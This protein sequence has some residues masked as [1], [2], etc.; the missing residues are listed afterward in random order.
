MGALAYE[1]GADTP[2]KSDEQII[3]AEDAY[4]GR[5]IKGLEFY[6][7]ALKNHLLADHVRFWW[8]HANLKST[9]AADVKDFLKR[10]PDSHLGNRLRDDWLKQAAANRAWDDFAQFPRDKTEDTELLCYQLQY[11][12]RGQDKA[13]LATAKPL[14]F[15]GRSQPESCDPVL[16]RLV[17]DG[18]VS[19]DEI[20]ERVRLAL[21]AGQVGVAKKVND[22]LPN[23]QAMEE[24]LLDEARRNPQR[25]LDKKKLALRTRGAKEIVIYAVSQVAR[26]DAQEAAELWRNLGTHFSA[27]DQGYV[28]GQI[29]HRGAMDHDTEALAWYKKA[30]LASLNDTQLAWKARAALRV[31]AWPEVVAAIDAMTPQERD[32]TA[33]RYWKARALKAI[34]KD[35]ESKELLGTLVGDP[36]YYGQLARE[37]LGAELVV[38]DAVANLPPAEITDMEGQASIKRALLL[39]RIG[40]PQDATREW[41]WAIRNF[42]D[43][44]LVAASQVAQRAGWYERSINTA[45]KASSFVDPSLRFPTPFRDMFQAGAKQNQVDDAWVLGLARQESRFNAEA[46]SSAGAMGLMQLMPST[47]RWVARQLGLNGFRAADTTSVDMNINLGTYYLRHVLDELGHPVLATAA[48]NAGPMRALRWQGDR[49]ME[50]AVYVETIPFTETRDYVRKVM[51]NT[52][53]YAGRLGQSARTLKDRLGTIAGRAGGAVVEKDDPDA[54]ATAQVQ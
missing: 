35:A 31:K 20:W 13:A 12:L 52:T 46:R 2:S 28:W 3:A 36:R 38:A 1:D 4:R 37:E 7:N 26:K 27:A 25:Y 33:W 53:I 29:A 44:K 19:R 49:A 48:Y 9:S 21:E 22:Y 45:E 18:V 30:R 17:F 34:D 24:K 41:I 54:S 43:R 51:F 32:V 47:A 10:Y 16:D 42:E 11:Q 39:H 14:W 8:L 5:D 50:G 23:E 6:A 15:A 40:L